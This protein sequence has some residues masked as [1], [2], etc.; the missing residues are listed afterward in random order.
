MVHTRSASARYRKPGAAAGSSPPDPIV[1]SSPSHTAP[2]RRTRSQHLAQNRAQLGTLPPQTGRQRT[3]CSRPSSATARAATTGTVKETAPAGKECPVKLGAT[4]NASNDDRIQMDRSQD[5]ADENRLSHRTIESG[6]W[7]RDEGERTDGGEPANQVT[8]SYQW[9]IYRPG[10]IT[11]T[12]PDNPQL[13]QSFE[14]ADDLFLP[15]HDAPPIDN[16]THHDQQSSPI[17]SQLSFSS[18][19]THLAFSLWQK[20]CAMSEKEARECAARAWGDV[21]G[22]DVEDGVKDDVKMIVFGN[23]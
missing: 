7:R 20:A 6:G 19:T 14:S 21:D 16:S 5:H 11:N 23:G 22:W 17:P 3:H 18:E 9:D 1:D 8:L 15:K 13:F 10:V 12:N 2:R 4:A